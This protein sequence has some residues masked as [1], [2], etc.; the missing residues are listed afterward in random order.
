MRLKALQLPVF[1]DIVVRMIFKNSLNYVMQIVHSCQ[2]CKKMRLGLKRQLKVN[3]NENTIDS[4]FSFSCSKCNKIA[5]VIE[6]CIDWKYYSL[7]EIQ[8]Y[9]C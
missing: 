6:N 9:F 7:M 8:T 5:S 4:V 1:P 2:E 3:V